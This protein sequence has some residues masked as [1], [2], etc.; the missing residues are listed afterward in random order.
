MSEGDLYLTF[1]LG[2]ETFAFEVSRVREVV[3]EIPITPVPR[4]PRQWVGVIN[5]RGGILS[6]MDLS[7]RLFGE[8]S[9]GE[10]G[11]CILVMETSSGQGAVRVGLRVDGVR[12]VLRLPPESVGPPP[13]LG[14]RLTPGLLAAVGRR[15]EKLIAILDLDRILAETDG[16]ISQTPHVAR[17]GTSRD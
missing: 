13:P 16:G 3:D 2:G 8:R 7:V 5:L 6:V 17:D 9:P 15:D 4:L 12:D 10:R 1:D 14:M 11:D